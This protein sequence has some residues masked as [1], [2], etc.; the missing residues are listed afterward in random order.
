[1]DIRTDE[2]LAHLAES[3]GIG[4]RAESLEMAREKRVGNSI[5]NSSVRNGAGSTARLYESI[6][7]LRR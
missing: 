1:L 6:L 5:V 3:D 2:I 7:T 4:L